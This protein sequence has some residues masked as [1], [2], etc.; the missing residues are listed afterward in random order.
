LSILD[1]HFI[2]F[3]FK[4]SRLG[5]SILSIKISLSLALALALA[6]R[7]N[8]KGAHLRAIGEMGTIG[9]ESNR[10]LLYGSAGAGFELGSCSQDNDFL[11]RESSNSIGLGKRLRIDD[12]IR[13]DSIRK[14]RKQ[15]PDSKEKVTR[16]NCGG[17]LPKK[18]R[19]AYISDDSDSDSVSRVLSL[20]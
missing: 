19:I 6:H 20:F 1:F 13:L 7:D 4:V 12:Q 3:H 10:R 2:S 18:R 15:A 8:E 5:F 16:S 17:G 9:F 14:H 11:S